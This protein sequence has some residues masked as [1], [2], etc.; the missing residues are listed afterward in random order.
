M[1]SKN[2]YFIYAISCKKS[3]KIYIGFSNCDSKFYNPI[4]FFVDSSS[5][6]KYK[7]LTDSVKEHGRYSHTTAKI[8]RDGFSS[9]SKEDAEKKAYILASF[10]DKNERSLNDNII[11]PIRFTCVCGMRLLEHLKD[12]HHCTVSVDEEICNDILSLFDIQL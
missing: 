2:T 8:T 6:T 5:S 10:Y 4:Q 7:K 12:S 3:N 1:S 11:Q 9:L